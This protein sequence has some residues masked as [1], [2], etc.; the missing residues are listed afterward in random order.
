MHPDRPQARQIQRAVEF[1]KA[2]YFAVVPTETTYVLM[3]LPEAKAAQESIQRLRRLDESHL[4]SLM[5]ADISQAS[6]Y[7]RMDNQ[8]H[9]IVRRCLPGPYTFILPANSLLP[10]RVFGKRK[11]VG[12]RISDNLICHRL[13]EEL[14]QPL[15][16]T[17]MQLP[18]EECPASDPDLFIGQVKGLS[19]VVL[20]AGWGGISPTTVVDL[21]HEAPIL[22]REGAGVWPFE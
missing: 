3:C 7:V 16:T 19:T 18:G 4:W 11:D 5:C 8:A 22:L 6:G 12:I 14:G 15:L 1:L 13:L 17:T 9:R 10:R 2:G 20:D 21:C